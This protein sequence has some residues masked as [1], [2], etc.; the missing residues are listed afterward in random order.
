MILTGTEEKKII[1]LEME[2]REISKE[3]FLQAINEGFNDI[4]K[5]LKGIRSLEE[6]VNKP[7]LLVIFF[8]NLKIYN[9]LLSIWKKK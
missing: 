2:G 5:I 4:D 9:L 1:M 7:K 6:S 8:I 3:L